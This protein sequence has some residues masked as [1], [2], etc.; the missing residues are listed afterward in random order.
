MENNFCHYINCR[1]KDSYQLINMDT[2]HVCVPKNQV[3]IFDGA[4]VCIYF[5]TKEQQKRIFEVTPEMARED[6]QIVSALVKHKE[7]NK[8]T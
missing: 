1:F 2:L 7:M 6:I 8:S 5:R 4:T 3:N